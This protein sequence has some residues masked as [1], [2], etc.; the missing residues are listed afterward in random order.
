M[1]RMVADDRSMTKFM[2][3]KKN[4]STK[5]VNQIKKTVCN[6]L[7]KFLQIFQSNATEL[8]LNVDFLNEI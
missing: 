3:T 5:V 7:S 4:G 6:A 1:I 2:T 8:G